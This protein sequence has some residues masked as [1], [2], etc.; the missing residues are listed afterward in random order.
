MSGFRLWS[1]VRTVFAI[2]QN[3]IDMMSPRFWLHSRRVMR[4]RVRQMIA[5]EVFEKCARPTP[6]TGPGQKRPFFEHSSTLQKTGPSSKEWNVRAPS[7]IAL[8]FLSVGSLVVLPVEPFPLVSFL[9]SIP[10]KSPNRSRN[11]PIL[12][13]HGAWSVLATFPP[14][15]EHFEDVDFSFFLT[16][17]VCTMAKWVISFESLSSHCV[18]R[19]HLVFR[20]HL[21]ANDSA[22][23]CP[24]ENV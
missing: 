22:T 2:R 3:S 4:K 23:P 1:K 15:I 13:P 14:C 9:F 12:D 19:H 20:T 10:N 6:L 8:F 17:K 24:R 7:K 5:F 16:I 21:L 18:I 11:P